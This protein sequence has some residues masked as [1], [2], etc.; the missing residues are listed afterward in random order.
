MQYVFFD[1]RYILRTMGSRAKPPE[2]GGVFENFCVK[3]NLTVCRVGLTAT[4]RKKLG[5]QNVLLAL[6]II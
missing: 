1:E 3:S 5:E 6:P 4:Y 2:A